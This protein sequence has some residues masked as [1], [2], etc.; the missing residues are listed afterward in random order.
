MQGI[1][2]EFFNINFLIIHRGNILDHVMFR[3]GVLAALRS[4]KKDGKF[5]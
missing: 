1:G 4:M 2:V 5:Q 3:M